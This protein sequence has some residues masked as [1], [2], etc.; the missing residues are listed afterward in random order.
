MLVVTRARWTYESSPILYTFDVQNNEIG[1][2]DTLPDW[3]FDAAEYRKHQAAGEPAIS[4]CC[5]ND[6]AK[7]RA[8][9]RADRGGETVVVS[10]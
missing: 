7:E 10:T 3:L 2:P 4:D 8:K 5:W 6:Y 1:L 9:A